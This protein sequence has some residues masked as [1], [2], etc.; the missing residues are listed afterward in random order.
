MSRD[1][2]N[3]LRVPNDIG[4]GN[5]FNSQGGYPPQ[6]GNQYGQY[7][8]QGY[9]GGGMNN[10][11]YSQPD[12]EMT[13]VNQTVNS[14]FDEVS[15]IQEAIRQMQ[16]NVNAIEELHGRSL[17]TINEDASI[18][19]QLENLTIQTRNLGQ[20]VKNKI[21]TIEAMNIKLPPNTGDLDVRRAQ[22]ANLRKKFLDTLQNYQQ[23]EYQNRQKYRQRM[24]RQYKI[25]K[26]S[27][28]Q[29]EIDQ[30]L[31]NDEGGQ[32]FAQS[33][34]QST[35]YGAAREALREVQER[36]DEIKKIEK[37]I[38]ELANLFQEMQIMVEVQDQQIEQIENHANQITTDMEQGVTHV[39][40]ALNHARSA[41]RN[42]GLKEEM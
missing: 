32:I 2:T 22:V 26:P 4:Y 31:D 17:A 10:Q 8:N 30:A 7:N 42:D 3:A 5:Q 9:G 18:K 39:E 38:E 35:R 6:G 29:D 21:R 23:T 28:T 20:Q 33:L 27:A 25:V 16:A 14:F 11:G 24:E 15:S 37:T 34:M 40:T 41:R 19:D 1:R 12:V 13:P 36:H